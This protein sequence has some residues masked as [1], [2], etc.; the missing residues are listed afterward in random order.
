MSEGQYSGGREQSLD[1]PVLPG[2]TL[3]AHLAAERL[4]LFSRLPAIYWQGNEFSKV[5]RNGTIEQVCCEAGEAEKLSA[6]AFLSFQR[7]NESRVKPGR[8]KHLHGEVKH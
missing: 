1:V 7:Q 2:N 6:L 4:N 3:I 8:L 5:L